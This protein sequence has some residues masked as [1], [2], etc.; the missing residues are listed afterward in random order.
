MATP[1]RATRSTQ[2]KETCEHLYDEFY[3]PHD[4]EGETYVCRYCGDRY[5]LYY[6]DMA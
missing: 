5:R 2:S 1:P 4:F 3:D 6:E